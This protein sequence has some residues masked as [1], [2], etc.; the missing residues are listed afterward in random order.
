MEYSMVG[1]TALIIALIICHSFIFTKKLS[2]LSK[3]TRAYRAFIISLLVFFVADS[4]WGILEEYKIIPVL[5][6]SPDCGVWNILLYY[7]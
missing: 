2:E 3:A 1:I 4:C 7:V 6:L 5:F